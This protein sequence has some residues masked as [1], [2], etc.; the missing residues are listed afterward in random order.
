M[1]RSRKNPL[2]TF[3]GLIAQREQGKPQPATLPTHL[4]MQKIK[5]RKEVFQHRRPAQYQSDAHIRALAD[6][7][8]HKEWT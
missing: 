2:T 5:V 7:A 3:D 8:K 4:P 1:S 6:K